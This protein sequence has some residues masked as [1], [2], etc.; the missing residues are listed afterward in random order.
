MIIDGVQYENNRAYPLYPGE[1]WYYPVDGVK[2]HVRPNEL[3]KVPGKRSWG[4]FGQT[5]VSPDGSVDFDAYGVGDALTLPGIKWGWLF[6]P[7]D[8]DWR[9]LFHKTAYKP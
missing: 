2:T 4:T 5:E 8:N 3:F 7:P 6:S 1:S 9:D